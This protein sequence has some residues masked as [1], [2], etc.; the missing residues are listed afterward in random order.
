M[1]RQPRLHQKTTH[2]QHNPKISYVPWSS[3][4]FKHCGFT[5]IGCRR[6]G[7]PLFVCVPLASA[8]GFFLFMIFT[9]YV[10]VRSSVSESSNFPPERTKEA[11]PTKQKLWFRRSSKYVCMRC[12]SRSRKN[13]A[14]PENG[15]AKMELAYMVPSLPY[16][17][18][19]MISYGAKQSWGGP[20]GPKG[21]FQSGLG[22]WTNGPISPNVLGLGPI[23]SPP[24]RKGWRWIGDQGRSGGTFFT[25]TNNS[26]QD[27]TLRV[28]NFTTGGSQLTN[29][30]TK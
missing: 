12:W 2:R 13:L 8:K 10:N 25:Q 4:S 5:H 26:L 9:I 16:E 29:W 14:F 17:P 1:H 22:R 20:V 27:F 19:Y 23:H 18:P 6:S 28:T 15:L 3:F 21:S 30:L 24:W 7:W 11:R